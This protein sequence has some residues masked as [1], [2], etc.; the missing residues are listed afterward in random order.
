MGRAPEEPD[1]ILL[2]SDHVFWGRIVGDPRCD[3]ETRATEIV[4]AVNGHDN[5]VALVRELRD[6]R[7]DHEV[8]SYAHERVW[9]TEAGEERREARNKERKAEWDKE[10]EAMLLKATGLS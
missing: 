5:L 9:E 3:A 10:T 4:R 6:F 8:R 2:G 7:F 1:T